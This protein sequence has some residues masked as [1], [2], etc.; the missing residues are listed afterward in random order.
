MLD[1]RWTPDQI[2]QAVQEG[3][4][5]ASGVRG[6]R[7]RIVG[8]EREDL[9][10][11]Y[12][13]SGLIRVADAMYNPPGAADRSIAEAAQGIP[14]IRRQ[15]RSCGTPWDEPIGII[16]LEDIVEELVGEIEDEPMCAAYATP[17]KPGC[18]ALPPSGERPNGMAPKGVGSEKRRKARVAEGRR[19]GLNPLGNP[20][21]VRALPGKA[22]GR[23][24][25]VA[26]KNSHG[27]ILGEKWARWRRASDRDGV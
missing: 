14:S 5:R 25:A 19:R 23:P 22:S 2:I 21:Q 7:T 15:M 18:D 24:T 27:L 3:V 11:I 12:T 13:T 17:W 1:V 10:Y 6:E 16:T 4:H 26:R 20:M 9:F 8:S